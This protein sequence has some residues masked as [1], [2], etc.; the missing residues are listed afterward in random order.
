MGVIERLSI[1]R[2]V[3]FQSEGREIRGGGSSRVKKEGSVMGGEGELMLNTGTLY[4]DSR[5]KGVQ[6]WGTT[7]ASIRGKGKIKG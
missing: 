3:Y 1:L 6:T 5:E 2:G 7:L 4:Q